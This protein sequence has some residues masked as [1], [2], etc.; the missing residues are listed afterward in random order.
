[1]IRFGT[2]KAMSDKSAKTS[3]CIADSFGLDEQTKATSIFW[4]K[5]Y[6][7]VTVRQEG[8]CCFKD[9]TLR[10]IEDAVAMKI[11]NG[12]S[13][14]HYCAWDN[15]NKQWKF[16]PLNT[17]PGQTECS[18]FNYVAQVCGEVPKDYVNCK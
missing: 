14:G 2:G 7:A 15:S 3:S 16:N 8:N 4:H 6:Q 5:S 10:T 18:G 12:A 1:M 13:C 17:L 9:A 11:F